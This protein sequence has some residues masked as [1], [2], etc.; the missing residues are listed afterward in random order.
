MQLTPITT[1]ALMIALVAI[2][3]RAHAEIEITAER[4]AEL[5][6]KLPR[7]DV[8]LKTKDASSLAWGESAT[9][10]M[11]VDLYE[12]TGD[13]IY[14]DEVVRRGDQ[15]LSHRDDK[16]GV[17]D[18]SGKS[19][20]AWSM[21]FKYVVARGTLIAADGSPLI[22][23]RS[24]PSSNNHLT[25]VELVPGDKLGR[26]ALRIGNEHFKRTELFDNLALSKD[27]PH[28]VEKVINHPKPPR[29]AAGAT[30]AAE[31][32]QLIRVT[33]IGMN[34]D[35]KL[36]AQKVRLEPIPVAFHAYTGVIYQPLL[37]FARLVSHDEKLARL[38]PAADRFV[39]TAV[40]SY[41]D[42]IQRL[43]IDGP[44]E[45]EGYFLACEKGESF[46][47][48]NI[49]APFNYQ[50]RHAASLFLLSDLTGD[51][52][53]RGKAMQISQ[54]FKKRLMHDASNDLYTWYYWFEPV[55]T[56]GW[57][58]E[59]APSQNIP[60]MPA[61]PNIE[62]T[63]H[64]VLDIAMIEAAH[65]RGVV[66]DD[67]D[68]KRFANTLLKNVVIPDRTSVNRRVDGKG[69]LNDSY[70]PQLR[71]WLPLAKA[72]REVYDAIRETY[73]KRDKEDVRF[74]AALLKWEKELALL[75]DGAAKK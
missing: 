28:F 34:P 48:D 15:L 46:P 38:R 18:G 61:A 74:T 24:T 37:E 33:V 21:A 41:G 59:N 36:D 50:G 64:G 5:A 60:W 4:A 14:L 47:F 26:F 75:P 68:L 9:L 23:V 31:P 29:D 45:G 40:E 70:A 10:H 66:F 49:G 52:S 69:G 30:D 43:W 71:G 17:T 44:A 62:D 55:T 8:W 56:T 42:A 19:R 2:P 20:P 63:S 67:Q 32:S 65:E 22:E 7:E 27:D 25:D 39:Q 35:A 1:I 13:A 6:G 16:R 57:T 12:A 51:A 53:Y 58:P 54:M 72:N 11:L 73:L 3:A